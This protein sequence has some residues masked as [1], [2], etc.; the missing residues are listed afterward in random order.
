MRELRVR[1]RFSP[2]DVREVGTLAQE[3]RRVWFEYDPALVRAG[4]PAG[5][6]RPKALI[7]LRADGAAGVRFGEGALPDGWVGWLVKF[8]TSTDDADV[9]RR[10]QAWMTMSTCSSP[11]IRSARATN[12][13]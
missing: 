5:S 9:G 6:A 2:A 11:P 1:L 12:P 3:G 13:R 7:G 8:P 10:E 4:G